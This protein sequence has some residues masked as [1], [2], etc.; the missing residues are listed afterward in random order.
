MITVQECSGIYLIKNKITKKVYIGS[1]IQV[2]QRLLEH[3]RCL[4]GNRHHSSHLQN[5]F[6]KYGE[7]A[8]TFSLIEET[9]QLIKREQYWCD[10]YKSNNKKFGYNV[11]IIVSTN[12]GNQIKLSE[13][14]KKKISLAHKGKKPKNLETMRLKA[15]KPVALY[16]NGKYKRKFCSQYEAARKTGINHY[17]INNQARGLTKIIRAFPTHKFVYV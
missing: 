12:K 1:S 16:I 3:L 8:F 2:R 5:A 17:A 14:T 15:R 6:N 10:Y 11:R 13:E 4:R 9:T 7:S